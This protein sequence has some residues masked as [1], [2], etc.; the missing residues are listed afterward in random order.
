MLILPPRDLLSTEDQ[1]IDL[2][3]EEHSFTLFQNLRR[4]V[5]SLLPPVHSEDY[6]QKHLAWH[7]AK[8]ILAIADNNL[9]FLLVEDRFLENPLSV[10]GQKCDITCLAWDEFSDIL[11]VGT[12][13]GNRKDS[14]ECFFPVLQQV[15]L[16]GEY[17]ASMIVFELILSCLSPQRLIRMIPGLNAD[18]F[19]R[20]T[21]ALEGVY[22]W[23]FQRFQH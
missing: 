15:Y 2:K 20:Y 23:L 7:K 1:E 13:K 3:S 10:I 11:I 18:K 17:L 5:E 12:E 4:K 16:H 19:I 8:H 22:F 14:S 21:L 9:I 6:K